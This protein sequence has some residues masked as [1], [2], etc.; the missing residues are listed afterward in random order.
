MSLLVGP[1]HV[2]RNFPDKGYEE[3]MTVSGSST[4]TVAVD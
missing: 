1:G 3:V 2:N 4:V